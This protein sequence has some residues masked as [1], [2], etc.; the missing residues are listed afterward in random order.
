MQHVQVTATAIAVQ[1]A[2]AKP[3]RADELPLPLGPCSPTYSDDALALVFAARHVAQLRHVAAWGKWLMWDGQ[4]WDFDTTMQSFDLARKVCR[5]AAAECNDVKI[6][7]ALASA[8]T[9]A[10]VERLSRSDRGLAATADVW[11]TDPWLLNT[12][13]GVINLRTGETRDAAPEDHITKITA[14]GVGGSCK[15][16]R[17][18]LYRITEGD[19][20]LELFLQRMCGY[21]LTGITREQALFFLHGGGANGKSVFMSTIA[22]ILGD[23]YRTAPIETFTVST[24]ERHPTDLAGLRG[25]RLVGSVETEEG[26][27]WAEARIKQL[28]GGDVVTARAMRQDYF[29]FLPQFKLVIVGNHR[30][31]LRSVDEAIRRR[32]H[33]IP[34]SLTIPPAERDQKL[35]EKLEPEWPGILAWMVEGALEWQRLGLAPPRAVIEA[36]AEYLSAED[37]FGAWLDTECDRDPGASAKSSE[38]FSSWKRWSEEASERCGSMKTMAAALQARKFE[39]RHTRHGN[40]YDGIRLRP[41]TEENQ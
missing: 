26:R 20:D 15:V 28:T 19:E 11:D 27:A 41:K 33:L 38:L 24:M 3:K 21:A 18:F 16:W 31:S 1:A 36:T 30:P 35:T 13:D 39:V 9:V 6:S 40:V 17:Q 8:A 2:R 10:A 14:A 37:S 23:Y 25:A 4:R 34:F 7:K 32:F 29:D 5:E 22:H 12:P